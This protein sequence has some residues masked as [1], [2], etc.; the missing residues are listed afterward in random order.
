MCQRYSMK[1]GEAMDLAYSGGRTT[2]TANHI[3]IFLDTAL[4]P[5]IAGGAYRENDGYV[6]IDVCVGNG[7]RAGLNSA[8]CKLYENGLLDNTITYQDANK[9]RIQRPPQTPDNVNKMFSTQQVDCHHAKIYDNRN[10]ATIGTSEQDIKSGLTEQNDY[11]E[12]VR[13]ML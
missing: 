13:E 3:G 2:V 9:H 12:E 6:N 7:G 4:P 10:R 1:F 8:L 11:F 5:A